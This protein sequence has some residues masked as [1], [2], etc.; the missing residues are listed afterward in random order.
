MEAVL[1]ADPKIGKSLNL[2]LGLSHFGKLVSKVKDT[3]H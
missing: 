2:D 3:E 1:R